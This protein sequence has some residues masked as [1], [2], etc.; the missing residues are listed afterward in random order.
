MANELT[1]ASVSFSFL[2]DSKEWLYHRITCFSTDGLQRQLIP[3]GD[4]VRRVVLIGDV[5]KHYYTEQGRQV[6]L[7]EFLSFLFNFCQIQ[8][9]LSWLYMSR[10]RKTAIAIC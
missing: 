7:F 3:V 4:Q 9:Q 6:C 1:F 8:C 5:L 2:A 10:P